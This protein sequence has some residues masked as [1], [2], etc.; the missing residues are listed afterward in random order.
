M[1]SA[2]SDQTTIRRRLIW[3]VTGRQWVMANFLAATLKL[4]AEFS[5][6]KKKKNILLTHYLPVVPYRIFLSSY[7]QFRERPDK[8]HVV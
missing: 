8:P 2:H 7:Q 5:N 1:T 4:F 6:V 3:I